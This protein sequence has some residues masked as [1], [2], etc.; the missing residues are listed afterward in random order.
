MYWLWIIFIYIFVKSEKVNGF[1]F[2]K[3]KENFCKKKK[4]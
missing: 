4:L 1:T 3:S 2:L